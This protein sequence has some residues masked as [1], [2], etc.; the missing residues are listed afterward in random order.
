MYFCYLH[1]DCSNKIFSLFEASSFHSFSSDLSDAALVLMAI[2]LGKYYLH[3]NNGVRKYIKHFY[4]A[5]KC[6]HPAIYILVVPRN[7]YMSAQI[8][9]CLRGY[10][11]ASTQIF[12]FAR[13][14]FGLRGNV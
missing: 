10:S 6:F 13:K 2:R 4:S 3:I 11:W 8:F 9:I 7:I 14:Y 12:W 5:Q 1:E